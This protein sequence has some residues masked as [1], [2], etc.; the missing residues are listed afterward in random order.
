MEME[1]SQLL[2]LNIRLSQNVTRQ[3]TN[4]TSPEMDFYK[5]MPSQ[6]ENILF[7]SFQLWGLAF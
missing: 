1:I 6:S 4:L 5:S 3:H 2:V 7:S